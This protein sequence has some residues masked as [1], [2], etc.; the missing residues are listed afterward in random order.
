MI[1]FGKGDG[2]QD[3]T[4]PPRQSFKNLPAWQTCAAIESGNHQEW[5]D[6]EVGDEHLENERLALQIPGNV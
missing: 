4:E 1:R 5:R 3:T 6:N 2:P